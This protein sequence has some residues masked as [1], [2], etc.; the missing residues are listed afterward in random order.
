MLAKVGQGNF[1]EAN[2]D[3][4]L[5]RPWVRFMLTAHL[6]QALEI[7]QRV[8]A[9]G[10][11]AQAMETLVEH[12]ALPERVTQALYSAMFGNT[13]TRARYMGALEEA[14]EPVSEQ[15][16]SRDLGALAKVGLLVAHGDKRGRRYVPS[17][18]VKAASREAGLGY[19][20]RDIDPFEVK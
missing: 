7:A 9:A 12:A 8:L 2:Y 13:V 5:A 6:N 14:G 15:T 16:A 3:P 19:K 10:K 1:A 17:E 20:W 4:E 11:A 18:I